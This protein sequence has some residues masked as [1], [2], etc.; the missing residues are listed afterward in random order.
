LTRGP[1]AAA[2]RTAQRSFGRATDWTSFAAASLLAACCIKNL[3]SLL[4]TKAGT[5][6]I[7]SAVFVG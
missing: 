2:V 6:A 7:A 3:Y 5:I 4:V 1:G